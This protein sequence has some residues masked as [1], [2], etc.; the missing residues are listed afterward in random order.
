[1]SLHKATS[2]RERKPNLAAAL[3][4]PSPQRSAASQPLSRI[5]RRHAN[6]NHSSPFWTL[7]CTDISSRLVKTTQTPPLCA[8]KAPLKQRQHKGKALACKASAHPTTLAVEK[9]PHLTIPILRRDN[10]YRSAQHFTRLSLSPLSHT[11]LH[12]PLLLA[13]HLPCTGAWRLP[14]ITP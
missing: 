14:L 7:L 5:P 3:D 12:T 13:S 9:V 8:F 4:Q 10:P 6:L 1:M 2:W 11:P